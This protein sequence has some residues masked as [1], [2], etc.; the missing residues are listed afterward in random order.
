[1]VVTSII[2]QNALALHLLGTMYYSY[3]GSFLAE[4]NH[5]SFCYCY[6][7]NCPQINGLIQFVY[8]MIIYINIL[9]WTQMAHPFSLWFISLCPASHWLCCYLLGSLT[10][11]V[12]CLGKL[13]CITFVPHRFLSSV[14]LPWAHSRNFSQDTMFNYQCKVVLFSLLPYHHD[15]QYL[16]WWIFH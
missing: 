6:E 12:F 7:A 3:T 11:L 9:G 13:D 1:M 16:R 15:L 10:C 4:F 2:C 14:R 8:F 5:V